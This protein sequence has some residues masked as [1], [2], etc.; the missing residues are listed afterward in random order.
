[1]HHPSPVRAIIVNLV[2]PIFREGIPEHFVD[3]GCEITAEI[4]W[5]NL[6]QFNHRPRSGGKSP[7]VEQSLPRVDLRI[8]LFEDCSA[9]TRVAGLHT[10]AVINL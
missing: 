6:Q 8:I 5:A 10:R 1:V 2:G 3:A 7:S 4:I 9:F